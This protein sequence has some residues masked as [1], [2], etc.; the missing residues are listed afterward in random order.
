MTFLASKGK[1][2]GGATV[3]FVHSRAM[4][5]ERYCPGNDLQICV[6]PDTVTI[7]PNNDGNVHRFEVGPKRF[8]PYGWPVLWTVVNGFSGC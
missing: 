6:S 4:S 1:D 3:L 8:L 2:K 7:H 5:E